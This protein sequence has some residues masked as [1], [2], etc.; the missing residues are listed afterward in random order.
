M[1]RGTMNYRNKMIQNA[2]NWFEIY[3]ADFDR[4]AGFYEKILETSLER[5]END[6]GKMAMFP[7]EENKTVSGAIAIFEDSEGNVVGL[8]SMS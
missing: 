3:A 4:A 6:C 7:Y 5:V 1:N 8:H 2:L